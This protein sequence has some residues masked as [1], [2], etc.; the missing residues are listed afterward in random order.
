MDHWKHEL[1]LY[2]CAPLRWLRDN[3]ILF[4]HLYHVSDTDKTIIL[5]ASI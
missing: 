5:Q 1:S 3:F 4:A 2:G